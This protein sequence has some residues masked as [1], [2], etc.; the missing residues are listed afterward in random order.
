MYHS[1]LSLQK[2]LMLQELTRHV[3][4]PNHHIVLSLGKL[5]PAIYS[6]VFLSLTAG[7]FVSLVLC[8]FVFIFSTCR[9]GNFSN[10]RVY[11]FC[12]ITLITS[13]LMVILIFA[14]PLIFHRTRDSILLSHPAGIAVNRFYYTFSPYAAHA[15]HS[16]FSKPVKPDG[17]AIKILQ[18]I[19]PVHYI[20][21]LSTAGLMIGLPAFFCILLLLFFLFFFT[22][23]LPDKPAFFSS[24]ILVLIC[25][26]ALLVFLYP[27]VHSLTMESIQN[28]LASEQ[29]KTRINAL[30]FLYRTGNDTRLYEAYY[31]SHMTSPFIAE[32]YWIAKTLSKT[33]TAKSRARLKQ[34]IHDPAINVSSAAIKSLSKLSCS[35][36]AKALFTD[37]ATN[38]PHWYIQIA[39]LKAIKQCR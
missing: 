8:L 17:I 26:I 20:R 9:Q 13:S 21:A 2:N 25:I 19:N 18:A 36:D 37:L 6:S 39:A 3:M 30:Q 35:A 14:D 1:N 28:R 7:V 11:F 22:K 10:Y 32:R 5:M 16:P 34:L 4:V 38:N 23:I 33:D 12:I 31:D 15:I 27:P 24:C 29:V